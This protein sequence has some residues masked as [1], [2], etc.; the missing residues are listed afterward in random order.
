MTRR[1]FFGGALAFGAYGAIG[2]PRQVPRL[3]FGVLSDVHIGGKTD[4]VE[5]AEKVLRW[6][7]SKNVDAV[8]CPGDIA[9]SGLIG[10]LEKFAAAWQRA[11]PNGRCRDGRKVELMISTGNHDVDAW[12][13]RWNGF[14]E[15][16]MLA[17]R[18]NYK[19]NPQKTWRRL[20]GQ[21][22]ELVW[23]REVKGF[24]FIGSQ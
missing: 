4:A 14:S 16:R 12:G 23:R 9:H 18:F 19:D 17:E 2:A 3:V 24:T 6:F 22:W 7:A 11:F 21:E 10:D 1:S 8:L 20:F 13:G 5:T 15:E